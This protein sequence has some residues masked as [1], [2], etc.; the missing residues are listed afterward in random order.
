M[1]AA[2]SALATLVEG[3]A[4]AAAHEKKRQGLD[5]I[6]RSDVDDVSLGE[7]MGFRPP[8]LISGPMRD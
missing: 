7:T 6:T 3:I 5:E 4:R 2:G 8:N 1:L